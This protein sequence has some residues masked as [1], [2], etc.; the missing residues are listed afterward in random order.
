MSILLFSL[1]CL[2][3]AT[4]LNSAP[5]AQSRVDYSNMQ[6]TNVGDELLKSLTKKEFDILREVAKNYRQFHDEEDFLKA[7]K[8]RSPSLY[9]KALQIHLAVNA[10]LDGLNKEARA[11]AKR[12]IAEGRKV[13][14]QMLSGEKPNMEAFKENTKKFIKRF[15]ALS[16]VAKGSLAANFPEMHTFFSSRKIQEMAGLRI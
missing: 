2:N 11:F 12:F 10:K 3:L 13:R 8:L 14:S 16:P 9:E 5:V 1:I 7:L 6:S 15:N 4:F